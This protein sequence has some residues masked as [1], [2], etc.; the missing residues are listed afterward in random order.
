M[1]YSAP[2]KAHFFSTAFSQKKRLLLPENVETVLFF[3]LSRCYTE[4]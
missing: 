4:Q 3:A 2:E 1:E